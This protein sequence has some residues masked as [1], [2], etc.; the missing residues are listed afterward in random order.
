MSDTLEELSP[1]QQNQLL[2]LQTQA[3]WFGKFFVRQA[4]RIVGLSISLIND[5]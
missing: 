2:T 3:D 5:H 4:D 1:S